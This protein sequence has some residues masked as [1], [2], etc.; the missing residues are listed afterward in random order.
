VVTSANSKGLPKAV[1]TIA[2]VAGLLFIGPANV[3]AQQ[4]Q[5]SVTDDVVTPE[6]AVGVTCT[7]P[8]GS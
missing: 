2:I 8:A 7:G 3:A 6:V 5:F 1:A 4:I